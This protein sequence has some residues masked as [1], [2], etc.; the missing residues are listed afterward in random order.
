MNRRLSGRGLVIL[1]FPCNQF[2]AQ[3]PKSEADIKKFVAAYD[4][5]FPMFSKV[6]VNGANTAPVYVFLK[7]SFPGDVPWNFL[8]KWVCDRDGVPV[9]RFQKEPLDEVEKFIVSVLDETDETRKARH[10]ALD[11]D[12]SAAAQTANM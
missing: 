5:A 8:G 1:A 3:E 4:V 9:A 10:A 2:G 11:K 6:D 7:K 12:N